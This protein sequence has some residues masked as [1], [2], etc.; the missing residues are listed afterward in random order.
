MKI[1]YKSAGLTL[2]LAG[3][4]V[5]ASA[6]EP[7][8]TLKQL[9]GRVFVGQ[10]TTTG[11][12]RD[13]MPLY[14][15]NRVMSVAGGTAQV[16]YP[17]GCAVAL[18]ENSLLTIGGADQCRTAQAVVRTT[19]G[20][21]DKA[22]G[23]SVHAA[24]VAVIL[25]NF[26]SY[27]SQ[28]LAAAYNNLNAAERA[29]LVAALSQEQLS[30]LYVAIQVTSGQVAADA[31]LATLPAELQGSVE[32][33]AGA[34]AGAGSAVAAVVIPPLGLGLATAAAIGVAGAALTGGAAGTSSGTVNPVPG[35]TPPT[36]PVPIT[37][38]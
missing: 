17:D 20:F 3:Y 24:K 29:E 7:S 18:P 26:A 13:A 5:A 25:N 33:L 28:Q 38:P 37:A 10:S 35:P 34:A 1:R 23:Q 8:A 30:D 16:V 9:N 11:P 22:I 14:A 32:A 19:A 27:N 2:M 6:V 31:F 36:P 4:A 15:G 21:Q 12:A